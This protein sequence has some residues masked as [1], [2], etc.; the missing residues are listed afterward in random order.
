VV[1]LN[2]ENEGT[3]EFFDVETTGVDDGSVSMGKKF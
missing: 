2:S 1:V 3:L